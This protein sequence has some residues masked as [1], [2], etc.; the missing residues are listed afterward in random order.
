MDMRFVSVN[1]I[2]AMRNH[3]AFGVAGKIM[4]EHFDGFP[5]IQLS[6]PIE[7]AQQL[8]FL[9]VDANHRLPH[10]QILRFQFADALELR[11]AIRILFE[12]R[13]RS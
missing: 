1:I 7:I 8:L 10:F 5:R 4:I 6:M 2:D 9:G 11:V 12:P 3:F 13:F